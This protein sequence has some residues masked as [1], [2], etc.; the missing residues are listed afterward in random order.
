M[1]LNVSEIFYSLQGESTYAGMPCV[2]VRLYGC[3]L[4]CSWCDTCYAR[5][6]DGIS[7]EMDINTILEKVKFFNCP[8]VEITG[9]EPLIQEDTPALAKTLVRE[10]FIV[11][12]ETNGSLPIDRIT[13]KCIRIVD[14][15]CPSSN[16]CQN[17]NYDNLSLLTKSDEI[18]FV[19][20]DRRDYEFAVNTL[21]PITC[22]SDKKIHISPVAGT[23]SPEQIA[24]WMLKDKLKARLSLQLHK[25]IWGPLAKGV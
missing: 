8:L 15:K 5:D 3:N 12:V 1:S 9:G 17:N 20:A 24:Q 6:K 10:G 2:F 21:K 25:I 23:I 22:I 7:R 16:E 19:I 14:I 13:R 18:K 11:L 4:S